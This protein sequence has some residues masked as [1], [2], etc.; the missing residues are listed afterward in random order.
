MSCVG[1]SMGGKGE[2]TSL[3]A[4]KEVLFGLEEKLY[5]GRYPR[6]NDGKVSMCHL[7]GP[8][9]SMKGNFGVY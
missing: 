6:D 2:K 8:R 7:K 4:T 5:E 1:I 3:L 9:L